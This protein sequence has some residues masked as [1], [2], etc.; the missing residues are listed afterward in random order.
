MV[1]VPFFRVILYSSRRTM[2]MGIHEGV[3]KMAQHWAQAPMSREQIV[4]FSPTLEEAISEDHPVRLLE[5]ILR[6]VDW[7]AWV[8]PRGEHRGRP[9]IH[10]R[11]LAGI[12][13]YGLMHRFRSS[14]MLE[15]MCGHNL[16][17]IWLAEGHRPDHT[18][19]SIFRKESRQALKDLFRQVGRL[20]MVMG[21]VRLGEVAFDGTRVKA[22]ANRYQTWTAEKVAAALREL[23]GL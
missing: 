20:A 15:Y 10:P 14:R 12:I 18:T 21:L 13:L 22:N 4:L 7:S 9:P 5:E 3:T 2:G 23:E 8:T 11:I 1:F 19:L 17:F 16:D 6:G